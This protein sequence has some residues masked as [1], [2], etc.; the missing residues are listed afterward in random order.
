LLDSPGRNTKENPE[1]FPP[2]RAELVEIIDQWV[3][4]CDKLR[5]NG[6]IP[7]LPGN[8][9]TQSSGK[10]VAGRGLYVQ[11]EYHC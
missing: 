8:A 5:A 1:R 10:A 11:A 9:K 6:A 2:I 7:S 3:K 4:P